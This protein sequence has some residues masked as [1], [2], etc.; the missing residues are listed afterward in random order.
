MNNLLADLSRLIPN[1][2]LKKGPRGKI[3]KTEIVE[4][5]IKYLEH[6]QAHACEEIGK[7]L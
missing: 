1:Y 7:S 5:A 3:E 2:Y 6:L 4:M